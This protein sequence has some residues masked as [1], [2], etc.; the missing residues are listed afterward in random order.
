METMQALELETSRGLWDGRTIPATVTRKPKRRPVAVVGPC[1][2][3][4]PNANPFGGPASGLWPSGSGIGAADQQ[5]SLL[6]IVIPPAPPPPSEGPL[7]VDFGTAGDFK[8]LAK[9]AITN[10]PTSS[11]I[12]DMGISP[13]AAS[14]ITGF[15]LVLDGSGEFSTSAQ[16]TGRVYAADYA[17][18]TP[19]KMTQAILDMEAAYTDAAGRVA[20][21]VDVSAGL[22][23]GLILVPGV[24]R[25]DSNVLIAS[26]IT[27]LGGPGDTW[28]LQVNGTL[29]LAAAM[30]I[31]MAGGANPANI[32]WQVTGAVTIGPGAT[33]RGNILAQTN[34]AVQT[35]ASVYGKLLAQTA[36]TLDNNLVNS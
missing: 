30:E 1:G 17:P 25:W 34:I 33:F 12:G 10:V 3:C 2:P 31:L 4:S 16:V 5:G 32:V 15:A 6:G 28:I 27:F 7:A 29:D 21:F 35:G 19:A 22:I 23:G 13:A 9:T 24:Y 20:D 18:P 14:A 36:V 26:D 11:V 8:I